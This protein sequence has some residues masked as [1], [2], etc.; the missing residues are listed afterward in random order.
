MLVVPAVK[1]ATEPVGSEGV[2]PSTVNFQL[3]LVIAVASSEGTE[4][5]L[6]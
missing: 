3:S 4:L 5:S 1:L 6:T 2:P